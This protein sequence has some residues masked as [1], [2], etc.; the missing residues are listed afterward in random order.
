MFVRDKMTAN[1]VT[2]HSDATVPEALGLMR[3][4]KVRRL[5]VLDAHG[6]FV[7]MVSENDLLYASP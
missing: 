6:K 1:P 2:I 7:G 3:E 5:P 4:K